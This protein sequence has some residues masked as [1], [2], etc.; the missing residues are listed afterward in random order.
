MELPTLSG[1]TYLPYYVGTK[2]GIFKKYGIK[3]TMQLIKSTVAVDLIKSG[4]LD[5]M[6]ATGS[7]ES[8]SVHGYKLPTY[9][10]QGI[11]QDFALVAGQGITSVS[12]LKGKVIIG[13]SAISAANQWEKVVLQHFG[14]GATQVS[15]VT[16]GTDAPRI[17]YLEANKG[18]ATVVTTAEGLTL[19]SKGFKILT[20]GDFPET[21][22]V[23]GGFAT[24]PTWVKA[25]KAL[26]KNF[27][28]ATIESTNLVSSSESKSVAVLEAKPFTVPASY[29]K[30]LWKAIKPNWTLKGKPP[31]VAI[32][33]Q[34][35]A[36]Q[37]QYT[38]PSPPKAG[39]IFTWKLIP[40]S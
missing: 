12:Q 2:Y 36:L 4:Q 20:Y 28:K 11:R 37:Q 13:E 9:V 38:L 14:I 32:T 26:A 21:E 3:L 7:A 31:Q 25:H 18:A 22:L 8:S 6:T 15:F 16:A 10:A 19:Q 39:T 17:A 40:S 24:S 34:L 5:M 33:N 1:L 27:V 30:T 35:K 23:A 29:A